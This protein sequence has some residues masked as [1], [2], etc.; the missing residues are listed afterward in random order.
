LQ[1]VGQGG[2]ADV[3]VFGKCVLKRVES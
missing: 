1:G 3:L 2:G